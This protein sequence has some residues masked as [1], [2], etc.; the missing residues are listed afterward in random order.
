M[1]NLNNHKSRAHALLS[2][3]SAHRWLACPSSAVAAEM[4]PSQDTVY[5]REG[6]LAHEVAEFTA[7]KFVENGGSYTRGEVEAFFESVPDVTAEM[8]ECAEGYADYIQ[9]SWI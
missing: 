1:S 2:A 7:R 3:S 4:Y 8:C 5:T 6:T 9:E